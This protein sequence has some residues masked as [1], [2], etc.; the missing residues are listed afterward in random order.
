[1][2]FASNNIKVYGQPGPG[3]GAKQKI[4]VVLGTVTESIPILE[5]KY[6]GSFE[7]I[8]KVNAVAR[9]SG[10]IMKIQFK[11]GDSV[12]KGDL[13][14][15]LEREEWQANVEAAQ[16]SVESAEASILQYEAKIKEIDALITYRQNTYNRNKDLY[17]QGSAVSKDDLENTFSSLEAS[18]A[19][20]LAAD[21]SLK[22]AHAALRLARANLAL[23]Q[24]DLDRTK[25]CAEISGK[26]GRL[27]Y[28]L[29]NYVTPN[30]EPLVTV[31]QIDPIYVKFTINEK[32]F[33]DILSNMDQ[34]RGADAIRIKLSNGTIYEHKARFTFYDNKIDTATDSITIWATIPNPKNILC[35]GGIA[36]VIMELK[37]SKTMA[38]VPITAIMHDNK[39]EYVYVVNEKGMAVLR[40]VVIGPESETMQNIMSGVKV[41]ETIV[42]DGT[43]KVLVGMEV[44]DEKT[45]QDPVIPNPGK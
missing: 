18:K 14:F 30:S 23:K 7:S 28:T 5:K 4:V 17:N 42:I 37:G 11:E 22:E 27:T 8:E 19:Q 34:L 16:A 9:V 40:R 33:N 31:S 29:G 21:A 3:P 25:I 35:P 41:G 15:E 32:D 20:R 1:M 10:K 26:T 6:T 36:K 13:L 12:K 44:V 43:H 24:L 2:F 45:V 38:A 39:G